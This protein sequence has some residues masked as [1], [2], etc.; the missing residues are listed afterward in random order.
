MQIEQMLDDSFTF[1]PAF[2]L[3]RKGQQPQ[4]TRN[5][6]QF[7]ATS[8]SFAGSTP[9][10]DQ[11]KLGDLIAPPFPWFISGPF[12]RGF[13]QQDLTQRFFSWHSGHMPEP[14]ELNFFIWRSAEQLL[15]GK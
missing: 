7:S 5:T 13:S 10:R 15:V 11:A 9:R 12:S 2:P 6:P 8:D 1:I 4:G 3:G 14:S